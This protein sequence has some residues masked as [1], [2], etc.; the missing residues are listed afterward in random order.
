[1]DEKRLGVKLILWK[2]SLWLHDNFCE[3]LRIITSFNEIN[4]TSKEFVK[5]NIQEIPKACSFK[6]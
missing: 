1:M 2:F 4:Y 3:N 6:R 5:I